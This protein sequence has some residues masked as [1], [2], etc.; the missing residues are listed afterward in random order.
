M[1]AWGGFSRCL[2]PVA[3]VRAICCNSVYI[4]HYQSMQV[5]VSAHTLYSKANIRALVDSGAMDNFI[6]SKFIK[7][8]GLLTHVLERPR[9][10]WNIDNTGNRSGQ[11]MHYVDLDM[12]TNGIHKR[13]CQWVK[14]MS[15]STCQNSQYGNLYLTCTHQHKYQFLA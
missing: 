13:R 2:N 7:C 14:L 11:I 9:K 1:E 6:N 3:G 15:M 10:I 5:L 4:M 8:L 12:C